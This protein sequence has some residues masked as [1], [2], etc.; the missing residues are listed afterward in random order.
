MGSYGN[1]LVCTGTF[2][3]LAHFELDFLAV[4]Q[5]CVRVSALDFRVMNEKVLAAVVGGNETVAFASVEPLNRAFTH[6]LFLYV[7]GE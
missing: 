3:T 5:R 1:H 2:L 4:I 6:C 7:F